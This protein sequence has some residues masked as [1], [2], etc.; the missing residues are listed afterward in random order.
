MK[1]VAVV[2][3]TTSDAVTSP[4]GLYFA[5]LLSA[6]FA[7][8]NRK[9][10]V[11]SRDLVTRVVGAQRKKT[12]DL[13]SPEVLVRIG[14]ALKT[15]ALV[16]G[17]VDKGERQLVLSVLVKRISDGML[18]ASEKVG[19]ERSDFFDS[20]NSYPQAEPAREIR[21]V[22]EKGVSV[23]ECLDCPTP[24]FRSRSDAGSRVLL[25]VVVAPQGRVTAV[26][27]LSGAGPEF[28]DEALRAFRVFRYKPA[29]DRTG[30]PIAIGL[31]VEVFF[32]P[33]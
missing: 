2:D 1:S 31:P 23:P 16:F 12:Y 5:D 15:E 21:R 19:L 27:V 20:L 26:E 4:E 6:Y 9:I 22:D 7:Q 13:D 14:T 3:F 25:I 18:I 32:V 30:Q 8:P 17:V 33:H 10:E 24:Q 29:H 11:T 28:R